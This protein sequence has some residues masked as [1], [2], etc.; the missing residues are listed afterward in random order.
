MFTILVLLAALFATTLLAVLS[1]P[2]WRDGD[3][4][5]SHNTVSAQ[6]QAAG[7]SLQV[8][9]FLI[10]WAPRS[11]FSTHRRGIGPTR[12]ILF[13]PRAGHGRFLFQLLILGRGISVATPTPKG[14][15]SWSSPGPGLRLV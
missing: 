5:R 2:L 6:I 4:Y 9:G 12:L 1:Q 11:W 3:F 14:C 15:S 7:L 10:G 13:A 8:G